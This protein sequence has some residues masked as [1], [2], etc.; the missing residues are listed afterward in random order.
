[1]LLV[2]ANLLLNL[3]CEELDQFFG[4]SRMLSGYEVTI[5]NGTHGAIFAILN[6]GPSILNIADNV[7]RTGNLPSF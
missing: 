1:M 3:T 5:N 7:V 6:V 4:E 2:S